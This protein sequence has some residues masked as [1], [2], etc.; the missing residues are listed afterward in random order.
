[1]RRA[2]GR[3]GDVVTTALVV[4]DML[5]DFVDGV[6][7][8]RAARDI[9]EPIGQLASAARSRPDWVVLYANDAH[10]PEDFELRVF[11]PHAMAGTAGAMVIDELAPQAGDVVVGKRAYSAFT[12]TEL[13]S[14]LQARRVD[15]LV[16]VG[17]HTDCCVRHTCYDAFT[18]GLELV[19]CP[20]ATTVYQPGS[21]EPV[22]VRQH[23]ALEYLKTYYG[24]A[25]ETT[26]ALL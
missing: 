23:H 7:P 18:R 22:S 3:K 8:N 20:D 11:A 9:V 13:E 26:T 10:R 16:I 14:V 4:V 6:L 2:V 19:V 5:R 15:R 12:D 21:H 24:A 17:Q 1:L 25:L